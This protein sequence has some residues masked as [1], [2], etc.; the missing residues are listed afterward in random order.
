[1]HTL[2]AGNSNGGGPNGGGQARDPVYQAWLYRPSAPAGTRFKVMAASPFKR[3]YHSVAMLL[4][5]ASVL[6]TGSEQGAGAVEGGGL[7]CASFRHSH[8]ASPP[9]TL[10]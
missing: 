5:D 2:T 1:L 6:V 3:L 10:T 4:P 8:T 7:F 9:A